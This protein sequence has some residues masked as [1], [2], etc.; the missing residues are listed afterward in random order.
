[1]K[2]DKKYFSGLAALFLAAA[3]WGSGHAFVTSNLGVFSLQWLLVFRLGTA[4]LLLAILG[5]PKWKT[6]TREDWK[7][8]IVMGCI[9]YGIY[10]FFAQGVRFTATSRASFIVGAYIIFVP[11]VYILIRRKFPR[12]QDFAGTALCLIGLGVILLDSSFGGINQGDLLVGVAALFYSFH[13]VALSLIH[14]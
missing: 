6:A 7:H 8:G 1:M 13:V 9:M 5:F 12:L 3:S 10:F 11:C 2:R 14:I 4:G